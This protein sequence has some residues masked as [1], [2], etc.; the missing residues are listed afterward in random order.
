MTLDDF[1]RLALS[2]PEVAESEHMGRPDFRAGG[3]IFATLWTHTGQGMIKLPPE[4]QALLVEAEPEVFAPVPGG[5][6][7]QGSTLVML[8]ACDE[9]TAADALQRAWRA[10][11]AKRTRK[12]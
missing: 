5:W 8:A 1:R 6:G 4:E 3:R 10:A 11:T 9:A 12:R 2:L 7:R